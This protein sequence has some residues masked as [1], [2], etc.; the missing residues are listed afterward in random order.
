MYTVCSKT[1]RP[2][3]FIFYVQQCIVVLIIYPAN[4]GLGVHT[5]N[6]LGASLS[7]IGLQWKIH[8]KIIFSETT[9]AKASICNKQQC[10]MELYINPAKHAGSEMAPPQGGGVNSPLRLTIGKT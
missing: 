7:A 10:Y 8:E 3:A 6:A 9:T 1:T 2:T 4:P 5:G